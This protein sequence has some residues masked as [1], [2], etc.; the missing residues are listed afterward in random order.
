[1]NIL[2]FF[3]NYTYIIIIIGSLLLGLISGLLGT[4]A[5]LQKKSLLG[6]GI[7]HSSLLGVVIAFLITLTK[8]NTAL[9]IGGSVAGVISTIIILCIT[10]NT[11]LKFNTALAVTMSSMFGFA[12][13]LLSITPKISSSS[14]AG[15]QD[16]IFGSASS[17]VLADI[18]ALSIVLV[19]ALTTT[20]IFYRQITLFVFDPHYSHS[21]YGYRHKTNILLYIMLSTGIVIGLSTVG[22]ILMSAMLVAPHIGARQWTKRLTPTIILSCI[23]G[24]VCGAT[25]TIISIVF[26]LPTGSCLVLTVTTLAFLS[27]L[28]SPSRGIIA[29]AIRYKIAKTKLLKGGLQCL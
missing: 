22:V 28:F 26:C 2:T 10:A 19:L 18:I 16:F 25:G 7:S 9:L 1:M 5:V 27:V 13:L 23:F 14:S 24:A 17:L 15:L 29:K 4:F 6:D 3:T 11:N 8:N 21:L 12:M 20:I